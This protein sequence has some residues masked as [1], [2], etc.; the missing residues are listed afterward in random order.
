MGEA[1]ALVSVYASPS[2]WILAVARP[3]WLT[4][5]CLALSQILSAGSCTGPPNSFA[6]ELLGPIDTMCG[7][8]LLAAH[9]KRSGNLQKHRRSFSRLQPETFGAGPV[10]ARVFGADC[11]HPDR[12]T[13]TSCLRTS[14]A[15]TDRLRHGRRRPPLTT[16]ARCRR[17]CG[18]PL[19]RPTFVH[20]RPASVLQALATN[21]WYFAHSGLAMRCVLV[22]TASHQVGLCG[23]NRTVV[24]S[25]HVC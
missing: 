12:T 2:F 24:F 5:S 17:R 9:P 8:T 3:I 1:S 6:P 25:Y 23:L 18:I 13:R 11:T 19:T 7:L 16:G 15:A 21:T 22:S 10:D 20:I 14:V 4:A